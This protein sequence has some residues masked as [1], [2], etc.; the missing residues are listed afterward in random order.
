MGMTPELWDRLKPL[1]EAAVEKPP[2]DRD[3]FLA[4][5]PVEDGLRRE[6]DQ[7]VKAFEAGG[8]NLDA[9]ANKVQAMVPVAADSFA[10]GDVLLNRFRI[11][12]KLGHGGMGDVYQAFDMELSETVALKRIRPEIDESPHVLFRFKREVQ[13]ARRLTGHNICRIHE[14]FVAQNQGPGGDFVFLT[15]EFLEGVTLAD[16]IATNGPMPWLRAKQIALELCAALVAMHTAGIVH[17]DVKS[18]NV[19]LASRSGVLQAVLMDFGLARD[20]STPPSRIDTALTMPGAVVGTPSYMAP[21][22]FSGAPP[23]PSTDLYAL[24]VVLYELLTGRTPFP[25]PDPVRAAILRASPPPPP[26]SVRAGLP[27][28]A[29][30]IIAKCLQFNPRLRYQS[31]EELAADLLGAPARRSAWK[32]PWAAASFAAVLLVLIACLLFPAIR[33]RAEGILFAA[34]QKHVAVLPLRVNDESPAMVALGEGLMDSLSRRLSN[35][36]VRN[37]SFWVV[38][39]TEIRSQR[40]QSPS[41]ARRLFGATMVLTGSLERDGKAIRLNLDL[42][43]SQK[44]REI[45]SAEITAANGDLQAIEDEAITRLTRLFNVLVDRS[46]DKA[47]PRAAE[48]ADFESYLT[49][50]GYM[51]RYDRSGNLDAAIALLSR[52]VGREP[53]FSLAYSQL[54]EAYRL[55]FQIDRNRNWLEIALDQSNHALKA[56][57]NTASLHITLAKIYQS[58]GQNDLAADQLER[59]RKLEPGN[60]EAITVVGIEYQNAGNLAEAEKALIQARDLRPDYWD[61]YQ[62]LANFY[63]EHGQSD[64]AIPLYRRAIELSADNS[65]LY[66]N[67]AGAYINSGKSALF[68][69]AEAAL[70]HSID[71]AP[72]YGAYSNLAYLY[73]IEKRYPEAVAM[74]EKAAQ[75]GHD[76]YVA[77]AVLATAYQWQGSHDRTRAV[78]GQMR[79]LLE[80]LVKQTPQDAQAQ[81]C[82]AS[83]YAYEGSS[84]L[85]RQRINTALVLNSDDP[86]VLSDVAETYEMLLDRKNALKYTQLAFEKGLSRQDLEVDPVMQNLI[87]DPRLHFPSNN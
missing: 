37:S 67:L 50:I 24:G 36:Q 18:R 3:A 25:D 68:P 49:A 22:Q 9:V 57:G 70:K 55:K 28:K 17:R 20:V 65:V 30:E 84:E 19:M 2:A 79:E 15:M 6:L 86:V 31:A 8:S 51:Q 44:L 33:D 32:K 1:F 82:L 76:D 26:S 75:L 80:R 46:A 4:A 87:K 58:M 12:R 5:V 29:D 11:I 53:D 66:L 72:Q 14:L 43:D 38:P 35:L 62:T 60:A 73:L 48:P 42:I 23:T 78:R 40:V 56:G 41:E 52:I 54:G 16:E 81:A 71:L 47:A 10:P 39:A 45:G 74:A 77:L 69:Q 7:L 21:E 13:L 83:V 27:R 59:A 64:K 34:S 85:A 63:D 61:G